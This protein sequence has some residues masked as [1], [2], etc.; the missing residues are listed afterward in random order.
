MTRFAAVGRILCAM[1]LMVG[2][3]GA[4]RAEEKS[5]GA[6]PPLVVR[7]HD[8]RLTVRAANAAT[9]DVLQELARSTGASIQGAQPTMPHISADFENVPLVEGLSRLFGKD[10]FNVVY[11]RHGLREIRLLGSG[12]AVSVHAKPAEP[13]ELP[14]SATML[15]GT[16][17]LPLRNHSPIPISGILAHALGTNAATFDQLVKAALHNENSQVRDAAAKV[18]IQT[19][20]ADPTLIQSVQNAVGGMDDHALTVAAQHLGG[21]NIEQFVRAI[22]TNA[23]EPDIR[24]RAASVVEHLHGQGTASGS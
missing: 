9:A 1:T 14:P 22:A 19:I 12:P 2:L 7:Y 16:L 15:A 4:V 5:A 3:T 18:C 6:A 13:E 10:S 17:M 8:E 23:N 21:P 20:E 24:T 11:G